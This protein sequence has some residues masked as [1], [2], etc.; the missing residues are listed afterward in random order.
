MSTFIK[1]LEI[2]ALLSMLIFIIIND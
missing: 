2:I 1:M